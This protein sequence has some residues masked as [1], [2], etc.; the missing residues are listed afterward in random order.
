MNTDYPSP[1]ARQLA[2]QTVA[3][4]V[5]ARGQTVPQPY[6]AQAMVCGGV[7]SVTPG[8]ARPGLVFRTYTAIAGWSDPA[9]GRCRGCREAQPSAACMCWAWFRVCARAQTLL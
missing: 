3:Y 4:K 1:Q 2:A 7:P 5:L 9:A 8:Q 6:L